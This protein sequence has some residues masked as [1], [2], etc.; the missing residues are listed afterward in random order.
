MTPTQASKIIGCSPQQVRYLARHGKIKA[1]KEI[2]PWGYHWNL[3][4]KSVTSY[5]RKPQTQG[6]PRGK[7][8]KERTDEEL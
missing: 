1:S 2:L 8:H 7:K 6:F 4:P 3:D 5:A